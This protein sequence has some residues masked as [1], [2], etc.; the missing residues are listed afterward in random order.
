MLFN[1]WIS[2]ALPRPITRLNSILNSVVLPAPIWR[3]GVE[4]ILKPRLVQSHLPR[5]PGATS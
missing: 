2:L 1:A 5:F 4:G 3:E